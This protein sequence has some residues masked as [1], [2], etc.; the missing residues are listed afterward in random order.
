VVWGAWWGARIEGVT[1]RGLL[2][3]PV[4]QVEWAVGDRAGG[5]SRVVEP[6]RRVGSGGAGGRARTQTKPSSSSGVQRH[7]SARCRVVRRGGVGDAAGDVGQLVAKAFGFGAASSPSRVSAW[8][9]ASRFNAIKVSCSH[10]AL[11]ANS[12]L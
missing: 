7:V 4:G 3:G 5:G 6:S 11:R 8:V 2:Q 1:L 10:T 12:P 9:Q